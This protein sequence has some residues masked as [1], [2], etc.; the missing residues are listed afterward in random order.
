MRL[1]KGHKDRT[2]DTAFGTVNDEWKAMCRLALRIRN[3]RVNPQWADEQ[4]KKFIG[5]YKRLLT[6]PIEELQTEVKGR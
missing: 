1:H 4:S 2:F 5:I 3:E 6:D